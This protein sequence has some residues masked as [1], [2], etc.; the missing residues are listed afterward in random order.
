MQISGI[1]F[2]IYSR[3]YT[4]IRQILFVCKNYTRQGKITSN[5]KK[6]SPSI[7]LTTPVAGFIYCRWF[8]YG[9]W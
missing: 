1:T 2:K 3:G 4:N 6:L 5:K 8:D 9:D 7:I